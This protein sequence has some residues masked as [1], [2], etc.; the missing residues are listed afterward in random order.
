M[1]SNVRGDLMDYSV[2]IIVIS[3]LAFL[4]FVWWVYCHYTPLNRK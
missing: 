4:G 2:E 3:F 1:Q